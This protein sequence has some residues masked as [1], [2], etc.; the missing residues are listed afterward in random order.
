MAIQFAKALGAKE[1]AAT[2]SNVDL[3]KK[4]GA[5]VAINYKEQEWFD[6]LKGHDYDALLDCVGD[7]WSMASQVL[8]PKGA[9]FCA[10]S[11][12]PTHEL[13][14]VSLAFIASQIFNVVSRS[15]TGALGYSPTFY[16][17]MTKPSDVES[18]AAITALIESGKV[19][20]VLDSSHPPYKLD[21]QDILAM[22][23][24]IMSN[25][26]KGKLVLSVL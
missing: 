20:P 9:K 11:V 2:S 5:D 23:E 13:S 6:V 3:V 8:K 22:F 14:S 15:I 12:T 19:R 16:P 7:G 25:R 21:A 10:V 17:F 4:L 24:S 1:V 18:L 26:V